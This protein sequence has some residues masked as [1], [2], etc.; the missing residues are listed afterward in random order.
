MAMSGLGLSPALATCETSQVLLAGVSG[1]F[2]GVLP[3]HPTFP[4]ARFNMSEIILK[5]TT[6]IVCKV[7][8]SNNKAKKISFKY[9]KKLTTKMILCCT[10]PPPSRDPGSAPE[11]SGTTDHEG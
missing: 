11:L 10:P 9:S 3:F 8:Y 7:K 4:L 2:P 6:H 5:E 1:G